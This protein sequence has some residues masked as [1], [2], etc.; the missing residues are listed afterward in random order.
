MV[1]KQRPKA[2]GITVKTLYNKLNTYG[3]GIEESKYA[4]K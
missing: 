2:L 3:I 1:I 4:L